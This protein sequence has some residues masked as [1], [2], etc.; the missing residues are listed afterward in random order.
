[1]KLAKNGDNLVG[2][3]DKDR[4]LQDITVAEM[5][6]DRTYRYNSVN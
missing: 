5:T 1:L 3:M 2:K 6:G 4:D